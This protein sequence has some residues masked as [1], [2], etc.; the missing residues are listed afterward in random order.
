MIMAS[1]TFEDLLS[2]SLGIQAFCFNEG[3]NRGFTPLTLVIFS[4]S[5]G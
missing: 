2:N 1:M 5:S 4:Y 3:I